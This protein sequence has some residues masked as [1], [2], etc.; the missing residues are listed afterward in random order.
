MKLI[1]SVGVSVLFIWSYYLG[2]FGDK[3]GITLCLWLDWWWIRRKKVAGGLTNVKGPTESK[4]GFFQNKAINLGLLSFAC[5]WGLNWKHCWEELVL[6]EQSENRRNIWTK[7]K[8]STTLPRLPEAAPASWKT[9]FASP[10]CFVAID[11]S[12]NSFQAQW[13]TC[14]NSL[15]YSQESMDFY[16]LI[17]FSLNSWVAWS[18][19]Q[20]WIWSP[21]L[22]QERQCLPHRVVWGV[23]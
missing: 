22:K 2:Q 6:S 3:E 7:G 16:N 18:K 13:S 5:K 17:A 8:L 19:L 14:T 4:T 1:K 10:V 11:W 21:L 12:L 15:G 20:I 23:S 9:H